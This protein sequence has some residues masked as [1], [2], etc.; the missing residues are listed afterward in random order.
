MAPIRFFPPKNQFTNHFVTN[1]ILKAAKRKRQ[2]E[3]SKRENIILESE[4]GPSKH[5]HD[6]RCHGRTNAVCKSCS[7]E[8][9][10]LQ[11]ISDRRGRDGWYKDRE[12][13]NL[14]QPHQA[15]SSSWNNP[16]NA[17]KY[18][19]L[20]MKIYLLG[21]ACKNRFGLASFKWYLK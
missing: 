4:P 8:S 9:Q 7:W 21:I 13:S 19:D 5:K 6:L 2:N 10:I 17:F 15:I 3:S 16:I 18:S 1:Y 11:L 20:P 12:I 14:L